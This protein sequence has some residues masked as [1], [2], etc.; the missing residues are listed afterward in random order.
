MPNPNPNPTELI[1][2][3][4]SKEIHFSG[5]NLLLIEEPI[6]IRLIIKDGN[7]ILGKFNS[8]SSWEWVE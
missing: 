1:I 3:I 8:W 2:R 5:N 6:T 4:G 7:K